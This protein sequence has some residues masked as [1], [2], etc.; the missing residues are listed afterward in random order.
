MQT[1]ILFFVLAF[2][3]LQKHTAQNE[4]DSVKSFLKKLYFTNQ[5]ELDKSTSGIG[6]ERSTISYGK[7]YDPVFFNKIDIRANIFEMRFGIANCNYYSP[8]TE[9][10][11]N[12]QV[13]TW[14]V[15]VNYPISALGIGKA[16]STKGIRLL[17]FFS[18]DFGH[19]AFKS[20][21]HGD[22][23][24]S[25][26]HLSIAPGYRIKLPYFIIDFRLN[27]TWNNLTETNYHPGYVPLTAN[28]DLVKEKSFKTFNLTPSVSFIFDGLFSLFN[29]KQ[30]RVSGQMAVLDNVSEKK[31]YSGEHY[32]SSTGHTEKDGLYKTE[33]TYKYHVESVSL[34]I[35]NIGAFLGIGPRL[36]F[37]PESQSSFRMPSL[38]AG[39]GMHSRIRVFSFDINADK[40][41]AG[42]SSQVNSDKKIIKNDTQGKGTFNMTNLTAN[43]GIDIGPVLLA[44]VGIITKRE[45]ETPYF[46]VSAGYIY[47]Y[48]FINSYK[49]NDAKVGADYQNYFKA[50]PDKR[51]IYNDA[52]SNKSGAINGWYIGADVGAVGFRYE[53]NKYKNAP[54]ARCSYFSVS[55]KYPLL[56]SNHKL[57]N[58]E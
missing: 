6:I 34:P 41:T 51:T 47:G 54:L 39:V 8:L 24:A 11:Y 40:G 31:Y 32:N 15:G 16:N 58:K 43:A 25:A 44:L 13:N 23:F 29:P 2:L 22:K 36:I 12:S 5:K 9:T 46:N 37:R 21:S 38:M 45:G 17:P 33:T 19:S 52:A 57:K 3:L 48:S 53:F 4:A 56:R 50:N 42:F 55:Y 35:S 30:S 20:V 18:A 49:Y 7:N 14:A 10:S 1:R 26:Y 28:G 27:T